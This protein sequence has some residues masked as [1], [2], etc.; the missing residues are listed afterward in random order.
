MRKLLK[1]P[2]CI[3]SYN[4]ETMSPGR[5]TSREKG[6]AKTQILSVFHIPTMKLIT[7]EQMEAATERLLETGR[8][9]GAD[10]WQQ[11][12]KNQTPHCKFGEIDLIV[13]D[14][15]YLVFVEVKLRKNANFAR[16]LEHVDQK[17]QNRLR[18]TASMYLAENP[19]RL[20]PRFDVVEIYAPLGIQTVN[21]EIYHLEDA[22]Q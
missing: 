13:K 18:T 20:Q 9:V 16:A 19:T 14:R 2:R 12:V 3:V 15:K 6:A 22:F 17:K 7:V 21:P 5:R 10:S 1:Y 11:R 4:T 8:Q